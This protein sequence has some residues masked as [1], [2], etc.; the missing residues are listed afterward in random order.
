[1]TFAQLGKQ[2]NPSQLT[3][4]SY[5]TYTEW[6]VDAL[7]C[8]E[9]R[10]SVLSC[11]SG[12]WLANTQYCNNYDLFYKTNLPMLVFA[13]FWT[14]DRKIWCGESTWCKKKKRT[15]RRSL[16]CRS[17]PLSWWQEDIGCSLI[18]FLLFLDKLFYSRRR[19]VVV[20]TILLLLWMIKFCNLRKCKITLCS[21][22][23]IWS[24]SL[25]WF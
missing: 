25:A 20:R 24:I 10:P 4:S 21:L 5:C 7:P 2:Y 19:I 9:D 8:S 6:D 3:Q 15:R 1:M 14:L 17:N 12:L 11:M 16:N 13:P 23:V 22:S 18:S